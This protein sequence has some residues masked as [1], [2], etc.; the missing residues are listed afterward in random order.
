M[1]EPMSAMSTLINQ[2]TLADKTA[3][4][5]EFEVALSTVARWGNGNS[6]PHPA[7]AARVE[8]WCIARLASDVGTRLHIPRDPL[9]RPE[10]P[11]R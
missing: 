3:L 5:E 8:R 6:T 1:N 4:A 9:T 7:I 2:I 11:R 10:C